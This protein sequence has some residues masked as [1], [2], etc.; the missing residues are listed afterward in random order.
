[1]SAS[2]S[3]SFPFSGQELPVMYSFKIIERF[4]V[5]VW[6]LNSRPNN[7]CSGTLP[8]NFVSQ[9]ILLP[10]EQVYVGR[11]IFCCHDMKQ[12]LDLVTSIG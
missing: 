1:V 9:L 11:E 3:L 6:G 4:F 8:D 7:C 10:R 5:V 12:A 2:Y